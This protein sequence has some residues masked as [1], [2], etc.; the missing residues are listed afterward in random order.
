MRYICAR[1][2]LRNK[3]VYI[4]FRFFPGLRFTFSGFAFGCEDI[5]L[6]RSIRPIPRLL[7]TKTKPEQ[8]GRARFL[9]LSHRADAGLS[10]RPCT[11]DRNWALPR[12]PGHLK[13]WQ[14]G[15]SATYSSWG[16]TFS[17]AALESLAALRA[18]RSQSKPTSLRRAVTD[19]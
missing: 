1:Y 6:I 13:S 12:R 15:G 16:L 11:V 5:Y 17:L 8:T 9:A 3:P 14:T 19:S 18:A 10:D 4:I 7:N 2:F